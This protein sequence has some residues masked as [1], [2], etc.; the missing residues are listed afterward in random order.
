MCSARLC[1]SFTFKDKSG[2][3]QENTE[4]HSCTIWGSRGEAFSKYLHKGSEV[5]ISKGRLHYSTY[6][7]RE[8]IKRYKTEVIVEEWEFCGSRKDSERSDDEQPRAHPN[9]SKG[10]HVSSSQSVKQTMSQAQ[11]VSEPTSAED[12]MD[13]DGIPF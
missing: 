7:D 4:W 5:L 11:E 12:F 9:T 13:D 8:G 3:K 1:T 6:E 2:T 10:N